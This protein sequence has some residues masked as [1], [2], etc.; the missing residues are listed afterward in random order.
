MLYARNSMLY[1]PKALLYERNSLLHDNDVQRLVKR[2]N[3][4]DSFL[5]FS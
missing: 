4:V 3:L 1:V 5:Y 2:L